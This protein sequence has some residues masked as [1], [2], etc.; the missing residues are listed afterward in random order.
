MAL[1][2]STHDLPEIGEDKD[3]TVD[4]TTST[5]SDETILWEP[6][7]EKNEH[8]EGLVDGPLR[9]GDQVDGQ[10]ILCVIDVRT[11]LKKTF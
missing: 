6:S 9:I 8:S 11:A 1:D 5:S 7:L 3:T 4:M 2:T 10:L